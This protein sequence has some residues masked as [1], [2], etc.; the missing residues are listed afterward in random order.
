PK[1]SLELVRHVAKLS[2]LALSD[3][4]AQKY[5][6][7]LGSILDYVA[8]ISQ[9]DV[10]GVEP[11]AHALPLHNVFRDDIVE[12]SLPVEQVLQNAPDTEGPFFKVPKIIGAEEDS[13]G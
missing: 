8:K 6:S 2:R 10:S 11:M 4:Q 9:V 3:E 1:I 13:A 12:P 5:T 7:Q